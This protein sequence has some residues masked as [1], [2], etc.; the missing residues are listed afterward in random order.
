MKLKIKTVKKDSIKKKKIERWNF[1]L[2]K[3]KKKRPDLTD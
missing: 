2:K 3:K 1:F